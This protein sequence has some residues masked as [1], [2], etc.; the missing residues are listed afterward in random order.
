MAS[1]DLWEHQITLNMSE[2]GRCEDSAPAEGLFDLLKQKRLNRRRY[3]TIAG[4]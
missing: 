3:L 4:A 1:N 2:L